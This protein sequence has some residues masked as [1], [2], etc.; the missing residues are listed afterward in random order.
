[1]IRKKKKKTH[2]EHPVAMQ[3]VEVEA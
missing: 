2:I 1:M 3:S